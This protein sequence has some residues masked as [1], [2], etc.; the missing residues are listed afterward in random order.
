MQIIRKILRAISELPTNALPTNH[1]TNNQPI[2]T[3]NVDLIG[4][5]WCQSNKDYL[6]INSDSNAENWIWL[7]MKSHYRTEVRSTVLPNICSMILLYTF[8]K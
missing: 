4:H 6:K 1:P 2:I 3:N 5:G 8:G 7:F